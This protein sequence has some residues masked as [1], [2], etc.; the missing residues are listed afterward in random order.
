ML[1]F[2][3]IEVSTSLA[4]Y[5]CP[6]LTVNL[7]AD[8]DDKYDDEGEHSPIIIKSD[9]YFPRVVNF[10]LDDGE[11]VTRDMEGVVDL[12]SDTDSEE[13]GESTD[14]ETDTDTEFLICDQVLPVEYDNDVTESDYEEE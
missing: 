12:V 3:Q 9:D 6:Q 4:Y 10:L 5:E 14:D 1:L 13:G 11:L 2:V 8:A 7:Y